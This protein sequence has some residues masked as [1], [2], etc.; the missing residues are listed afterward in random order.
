MHSY[1]QVIHVQW[2]PKAL[3]HTVKPTLNSRIKMLLDNREIDQIT[4]K[5]SHMCHTFDVIY[6]NQNNFSIIYSILKVNYFGGCFIQ[7][8]L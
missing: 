4:I 6:Y 8:L 5:A 1:T 3:A 7:V 2:H